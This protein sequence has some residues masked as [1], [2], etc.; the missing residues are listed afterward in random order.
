MKARP[1]TA[2]RKPVTAFIGPRRQQ[3][4]VMAIALIMLL[5]LT[6]IGVTSMSSGNL[7]EVMARNMLDRN[8]AFQAGES[9]LRDAEIDVEINMAAG[10]NF[11]TS[12]T[13]GLCLPTASTG[14]PPVWESIDWDDSSVTRDFGEYTGGTPY[15]NKL[16]PSLAAAPKYIVE[17]NDIAC[18]PTVPGEE[19][20]TEVMY[21]KYRITSQATGRS[22]TARIR[23]QSTYRKR[24]GRC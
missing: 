14:D 15:K 10:T 24:R 7:Q 12:C 22:D 21:D 23:L 20:G 13:N 19:L 11:D 9:G 2:S 6:I 17:Y 4:V 18:D 3:G 5:M 1:G 16:A 8:Y